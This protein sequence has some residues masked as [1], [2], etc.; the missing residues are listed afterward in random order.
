MKTFVPIFEDTVGWSTDAPSLIS[1]KTNGKFAEI[2][3]N[4]LLTGNSD[5]G[6]HSWSRNKKG[7]G[8]EQLRASDYVY[9]IAFT[10]GSGITEY[11][12]PTS[13]DFAY[14]QYFYHHHH[15]HQ[16]HLHFLQNFLLH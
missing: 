2:N 13:F 15:L 3:P 4:I 14:F 11:L 16:F 1:F 12:M 6:F 8:I 10:D 7:A 9:K 5:I